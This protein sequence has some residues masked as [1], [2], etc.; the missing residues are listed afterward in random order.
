M[1]RM[2][3][4]WARV[5]YQ[6]DLQKPGHPIPLGVVL[7]PELNDRSS[8]IVLGREPKR[9]AA[10]PPELGYVGP[11]GLSQLRGWA[12]AIVRDAQE[13]QKNKI[14]PFAYLAARWRWNVYVTDPEQIDVESSEPLLNVAMRL[15]ENYVKE[16]FRTAVAGR[17]R[18][19][20]D[21]VSDTWSPAE[22][23]YATQL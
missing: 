9:D 18:D 6:R 8:G 19:E 12:P 11:L 3:I 16:P 15:F 20:S 1:S 14:D 5:E 17:V 10:I 7:L 13:A 2:S 23:E 22:V 21:R 4:R